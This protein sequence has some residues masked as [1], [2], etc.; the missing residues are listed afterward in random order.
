MA[1]C[2]CDT[3]VGKLKACAAALAASYVFIPRVRIETDVLLLRARYAFLWCD[4]GYLATQR[5]IQFVLSLERQRRLEV[6]QLSHV[7]TGGSVTIGAKDGAGDTRRQSLVLLGGGHAHAYTLKDYVRAPSPDVDVTLISRVRMTPYSGMLPGYIAGTYSF[8]E[9][10]IDLVRLCAAGGIRL[11]LSEAQHIDTDAQTVS[12][13]NGEKVAYDVLSVDIGSAPRN[14]VTAP[15][16]TPVKPIDSFNARWVAMLAGA[17]ERVCAGRRFTLAVVGSGAAGCEM[18]LCMEARLVREVA[19]AGGSPA[20]LKVVLVGRGRDVLPAHCP[21]ARDEMREELARR[22]IDVALCDAGRGVVGGDEAALELADGTRVA[23]D[24]CLWCTEAG[25]AAWLAD[26]KLD[27]D[28]GFVKVNRALQS[29][30]H[31]NV[32]AA[33]DCAGFP[34]TLPKAGVFAVR[35][36]PVLTANVRA[37]LAGADANTLVTFVPPTSFLAL[38]GT[39]HPTRCIASRGQMAC[40]SAWLWEL[41]DWIDKTW[42][43]DY[44]L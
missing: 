6:P 29:T 9:C 27:L 36:G 16:I 37:V 26:T 40:T 30:S 14:A 31:A 44:S 11:V 18:V 33:G 10:H 42:M 32:F 1:S 3:T 4:G 20:L 2:G 17:V 43:K 24:E 15:T 38:I 8:E 21:A 41:K 13:A 35:Q 7:D 5:E 23:C 19:K 28:D 34:G 39:G 12:C 25:T 22:G